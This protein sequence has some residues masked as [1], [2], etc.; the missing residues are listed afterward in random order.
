LNLKT[1][2]A[3]FEL[4]PVR[5]FSILLKVT[6]TKPCFCVIFFAAMHSQ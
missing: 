2:K 6:N 3:V 1:K 5:F 4:F